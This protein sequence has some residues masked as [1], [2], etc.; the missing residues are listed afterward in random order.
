[1]LQVR[2][3]CQLSHSRKCC[4]AQF[5]VFVVPVRQWRNLTRWVI[6]LP[7]DR[8]LL[9]RKKTCIFYMENRHGV[10]LAYVHISSRIHDVH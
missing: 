5:G 4:A 9:L 6:C 7:L 1:M 3:P 2:Q 10:E 8:H